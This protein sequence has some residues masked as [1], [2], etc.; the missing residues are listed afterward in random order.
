MGRHGDAEKLDAETRRRG[1]KAVGSKHSKWGMRNGEEG[2]R[3][4]FFY[5]SNKFGLSRMIEQFEHL[6]L[7]VKGIEHGAWSKRR[8]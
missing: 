7:D 2:K 6:E 1:K 5:I 8:G 4:S 3:L